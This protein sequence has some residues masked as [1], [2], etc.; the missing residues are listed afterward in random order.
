MLY[1]NAKQ[2]NKER[3]EKYDLIK[4]LTHSYRLAYQ[5][6]DWHWCYIYRFL[7]YFLKESII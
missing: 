4:A 3:K 7:Y 2:T 5:L 6:R 1:V